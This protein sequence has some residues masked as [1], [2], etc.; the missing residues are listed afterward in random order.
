MNNLM[1]FALNKQTINCLLSKTD[2]NQN[3][4]NYHNLRYSTESALQ[5]TV[6]SSVQNSQSILENE[7]ELDTLY[8]KVVVHVRG[9]DRKVLN[10]YE[11]FVRMTAQELELNLRQVRSP[12]RFIE[13]WTLLKSKFVNRKHLRQYEM[14]TYFKEFEFSNL[15]GSTCD[16]L[17]EYIQRNLPEGVAMHVHQTKLL[18]LSKSIEIS[19]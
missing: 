7:Q 12:H 19:E 15:T 8:K 6:N 16:T 1:R 3:F 13:R 14:R 2:V 18:E 4:F 10:S 11:I 17:L 5:N 9:H